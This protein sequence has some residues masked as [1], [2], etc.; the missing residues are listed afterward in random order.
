MAPLVNFIH[1]LAT[2]PATQHI[3]IIG[4]CFG[5]Q[6]V[7]MAL[8]GEC[9]PGQ[10]GWEIGVYGTDLTPEGKFWWCGDFEGQGGDDIIVS[11]LRPRLKSC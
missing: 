3:R 4:V 11:P 10:N 1:D 8:G 9:V 5:H 6:M 2:N 7:A